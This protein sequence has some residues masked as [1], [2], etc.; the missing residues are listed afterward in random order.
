[1]AD[2]E[3]AG[4]IRR[5]DLALV[6][7]PRKWRR[8]EKRPYASDILPDLLPRLQSLEWLDLDTTQIDGNLLALVNSHPRL[9]TVG[10][11]DEDLDALR[12]LALS[13]SLSLSKIR[14]HQAE[15]N[16]TFTLQ[17]SEL[18]PLMSRGPRIAHLALREGRNLKSGTLFLPGLE[19]LAIRIPFRPL[20]SLSW[21]PAFAGRHTSLHFIKLSALNRTWSQIPEIAF[22]LQFIDQLGRE[23]LA[24][25]VDLDA[26]SICRTASASSLDDWRIVAL[27][28]SIV[29][30]GGISGLGIVSSITPHVSSLVVRMPLHGKHPVHF[31]DVI[32][33]LSLFPRLRRLELHRLSK[34]LV[35]EEQAPWVLPSPDL[36]PAPKTSKCVSAHSALLSIAAQVARV[37]SLDFLR[38]T[39]Q[40]TD[41]E[42]SENEKRIRHPWNLKATYEIQQNSD[43]EFHGTPQLNVA[44][45]YHRSAVAASRPIIYGR[46]L[47]PV[48]LPRSMT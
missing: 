15:I 30:G 42:L 36:R 22:P 1:M 8:D 25:S 43:L 7:S 40:G 9:V 14:V 31:H 38:I 47:R 48:I 13:T 34:H 37:T 16:C 23:S 39:D 46:E 41:L 19:K 27:E 17:C 29:K 44:N 28:I 5:L 33:S 32:S 26:F 6:D 11:C 20:T 10:I 21:L 12:K 4:L 3:F 18:D 24:L 45:R 35:L 2:V